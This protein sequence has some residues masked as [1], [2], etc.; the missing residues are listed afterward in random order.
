MPHSSGGGSHGGGSH[1]GSHHSSHGGSGGS[2]RSVKTHYFPGATRYVYYR[3]H[4]PKYIYANYDITQK[5]SKLRYALLLFYVPFFFAIL[6]LFLTAIHHPKKMTM[7]YNTEIVIEDSIAILEDEAGLKESL[8]TFRDVTGITP[9]VMTVYNED[10]QGNYTS[11]EN[12][13][14]DLYVNAFSDEKHWLIVYS[15]PRQTDGDFVDWYWEGMQGD[16]TDGIL[17]T[18]AADQFNDTL[19]KN[20]LRA[21]QS[22]VGKAIAASFAYSSQNIME[23][24]IDWE[25]MFMAGIMGGFVFFHM[26][27]MVFFDP[28]NK[29]EYR[30]AS[31]CPT[32]VQEETCEYC[33]GVYVIGTCLSCPHCSAPVKPHRYYQSEDGRI[34]GEAKETSSTVAGVLADSHAEGDHHTYTDML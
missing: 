15:Q 6:S 34:I 12:Y 14:F 21:D 27:F 22:T 24:Y 13:A 1:G 26:F 20:L 7:D 28:G 33:G 18:K 4:R 17:T 16:D 23:T 29:K 32:Y 10:W 3:D 5:R 25:S 8:Q 31:K 11:L 9:A 2:S 19:Q 30:E